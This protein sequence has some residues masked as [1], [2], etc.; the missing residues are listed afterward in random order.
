MVSGKVFRADASSENLT[1]HIGSTLRTIRKDAG[2]TQVE[3]AKRLKIS[4]SALSHIEQRSDILIS[5]LQ[6]YI[7]ALGAILK[8]DAHFAGADAR[9]KSF[10]DIGVA[11]DTL[12]DDQLVLPIIGDDLFP[13][14]RDV[15]FSIKPHYSEAIISGSKT[16]ELRRRFPTNV[17]RGTFA[18]IYSTTPVRALTGIAQ[19]DGVFKKHPDE[20]WKAY[21]RKSCIEKSD[22]D[23]YFSGLEFGYA[24]KLRHARALSRPIELAELRERFNFEPPQSFL[25]ARP[26]LREALIGEYTELP[27]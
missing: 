20:I 18:L 16:I 7:E 19:I 27:N 1:T 3:L 21:S 14:K 12:H 8:I 10:S 23:A 22:F 2:L 13:S 26:Q 9:V 17:P 4:Q 6:A 11:N 15:V 5:T 24:V 25:Y